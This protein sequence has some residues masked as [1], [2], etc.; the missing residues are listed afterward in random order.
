M[1]TRLIP[2]AARSLEDSSKGFAYRRRSPAKLFV[3]VFAL[4]V[5]FW[6]AGT[7]SIVRLLPGLPVSAL[8]LVCPAIAASILVHG[9]SGS[10]GVLALLRRSL[11][12][13]RIRAK[14]WYLPAVLLTPAVTVVAYG[15]MRWMGL[16]LP[17]PQFPIL[18]AI[19]IFLA[20]FVGA[21]GEELGWSG[22][23]IDPLQER[24]SALR[25]AIVLGL[26]W[27]A[28]HVIPLVQAGRSPAWI[29]WWSL[30]TVAGRV[31]LTWL[32]NNTGKSVFAVALYHAVSNVSWQLFPNHGSHWDP[33]IVGLLLAGAAAIVTVAWGRR[34]LARF[35]DPRACAVREAAR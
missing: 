14:V 16:P 11:D 32:Y 1:S 5:P 23:A 15:V 6:I 22:Y 25:A 33:R 30:H 7:F 8:Q 29:A 34:R 35:G 20:S 13:E 9:E 3:L 26:V 24:S 17:A 19:G 10:A 27:A 21:L 31:L 18:A 4:S 28:W 2:N 12:Y